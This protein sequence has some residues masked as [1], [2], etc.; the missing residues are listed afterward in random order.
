MLVPLGGVPEQ[1]LDFLREHDSSRFVPMPDVSFSIAGRDVM[2]NKIS[3]RG[4]LI[5]GKVEI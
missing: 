3:E 5:D 4:R 1:F 2:I